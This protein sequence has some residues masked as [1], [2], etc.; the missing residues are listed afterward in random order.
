MLHTESATA[1]AHTL[2]QFFTEWDVALTD[3]CVA[4]Y[5]APDTEIAFYVDGELFEGDPATIEIA[6]HREIA[7]VIGTPPDDDPGLV[8][9]RHVTGL[10]AGC[11]VQVPLHRSPRAS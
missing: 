11:K 2:G 5:C 10:R 6:D 3:E 4:D 7:I 9:L 1:E 8:R